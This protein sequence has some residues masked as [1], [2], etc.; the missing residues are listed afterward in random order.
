MHTDARTLEDD[1]LI[2]ADLCI[3]GAGAAGISMAMEWLGTAHKVVL[4]EG[5]GFNPELEMQQMYRGESLGAPYQVPLEF[6]RLHYFG[7]TT[8]HWAGWCAPLDPIDFEKRD[9]V[10]HSGW[11]IT[12]EDLQPFYTRTQK[13]VELGPDTYDVDY[14]EAQTQAKKRLPLDPDVV[15]T[16]MWQFSPP[17]RFGTTYRDAIVDAE[18]IHLLTYAK[19]TDIVADEPV[20]SVNEVQVQTLNGKT[21]QIKARHYVLACGSIQNARLLLASN[22]QAKAGLGND[23]DQVG[24]YFMEHF[25]MGGAQLMLNEASDLPLYVGRLSAPR[26]PGGE[27]ALTAKAQKA[28]R[29]LNGTASLSPG[30]YGKEMTSFFESFKKRARLWDVKESDTNNRPR[31]RFQRE[32]PEEGHLAWRMQ[33]RAEQAPNPHSRVKLSGEKDALGMPCADLLWQLTELDKRSM[34]VFYE[35]LGQEMGKRDIGRMQILD[36]LL[37]DDV[38]W[39]SFLGGGFHHMGTTR[40]HD[41]P[42][43]GVLDADGKVH[44]MDNLHVAGASMFTTAGAANPTLTLIALAI[45]LSDHLKA[46]V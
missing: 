38:S 30:R 40:M 41:D 13:Y 35:V 21:H 18:N 36:W 5:G 45:R 44:G 33:S 32:M 43:Q 16:K 25:E 46:K 29:V 19:V 37:D 23:N 42:K 15:W 22:K 4:L 10:P 24:R 11:P 28:H 8:G 3:V 20:S 31:R 27:L 2:E 9:W 1:T 6:A 39:P 17:T 26:V 7:G 12:L 14:F 34:R